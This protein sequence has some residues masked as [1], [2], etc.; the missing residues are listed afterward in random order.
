MGKILPQQKLKRM[1]SE[2]RG[3]LAL[4]GNGGVH[5]YQV[6]LFKTIIFGVFRS[7]TILVYFT[8]LY[9]V[10]FQHFLRKMLVEVYVSIQKSC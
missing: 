2:L 9:E 4:V 10:S 6:F 3:A 5:D 1:S 7:H 8:W